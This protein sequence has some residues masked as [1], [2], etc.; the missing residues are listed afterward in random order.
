MTNVSN[1]T[2]RSEM[3]KL[4]V[5]LGQYFIYHTDK[6][7]LA[8]VSIYQAIYGRDVLERQIIFR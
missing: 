5:F 7:A 4:S 3:Y 6:A 1:I 8:S 2:I